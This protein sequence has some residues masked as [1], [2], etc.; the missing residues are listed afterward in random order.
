MTRIDII[1]R[2]DMNAEQASVY[3]AS[4]EAGNPLGGPFSAYIRI[5]DLFQTSQDMRNSLGAG[6][7]SGRE[8]QIVFLVVSRHWNA[9]YPW[10]AQSRNGLKIG[11]DREI[12]DAINARQE[13]ELGDERERICFAVASEL[14]STCKLSESSYAAAEAVMGE[15]DLVALVAATGQFVMTCCT[16]NAFDVD[17]PEDQPVP[18]L[19]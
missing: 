8:R 3:D 13:P 18:L 12:I 10:F 16:A 9:R 14:Q 6:P 17:P 7:L 11:L 2:D 1:A 15:T 19:A 5:P 4:K